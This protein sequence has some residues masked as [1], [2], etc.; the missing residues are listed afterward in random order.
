MTEIKTVED[1]YKMLCHVDIPDR[2]QRIASQDP[3]QEGS[4]ELVGFASYALE[5]LEAEAW[6]SQPH[7]VFFRKKLGKPAREVALPAYSLLEEEGALHLFAFHY[8]SAPPDP[9]VLEHRIIERE[10]TKLE[11]LVDHLRGGYDPEPLGGAAAPHL[12]AVKA[13]VCSDRCKMIKYHF[14]TNQR[15]NERG[16]PEKTKHGKIL[17]EVVDIE[18]LFRWSRGVTSRSEIEINISELMGAEQLLALR[19]PDTS[20]DVTTFLT[21]LPGSFLAELYENYDNRLLELNVRSYLSAKGKINRGI[22]ETLKNPEQRGFFLPYNNGIVMV[23]EELQ[24]DEVAPSVCALKWMRGVQ[25]VN[26]GQTTAS[27][28]KARRDAKNDDPLG[29]VYIQAKIVRLNRTGR[30][31]EIVKNISLYANRQNKV[32]MADLGANEA[33]HR[34]LE[35]L[36]QREADPKESKYWFYERM[37]N[38]YATQIML[39]ASQ[40]RRRRWQDQHPKERVITK[41]DLAKYLLAWDRQPWLVAKGGQKCF[42]AFSQSHHVKHIRTDDAAEKEVTS[43]RFKEIIGKAIVYRTVHHIIRVDKESFTS[44]QINTATYTVA[45]L[46][47]RVGAALDWRTIWRNQELSPELQSLAKSIARRIADFIEKGAEGKLA[48]EVCK[49]EGLFADLW[50]DLAEIPLAAASDGHPIVPIEMKDH[51]DMSEALDPEDEQNI[52]EVMAYSPD[53]YSSLLQIART[54]K[55]VLA[56]YH[57]GVIENL[58]ALASAGWLEKPRPKQAKLFLNAV[59]KLETFGLIQDADT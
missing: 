8:D 43:D 34:R 29:N 48:S 23:V 16:R 24:F 52:E 6:T 25:I 28:F 15:K 58:A 32:E 10:R 14:V 12:A 38:S 31:D 5:V 30:E 20:P 19:V 35:S 59:A 50:R 22:Q 7:Q 36:A 54:N 42:D 33:F 26:G 44:N 17:S 46:S 45:Y 27:L 1:F 21:V 18:R 3:Q 4:A 56:E 40:S 9:E 47:R 39:E 2:A 41:T 49:R 53:R 13:F 57:L 55:E 37:R 11:S 51:L